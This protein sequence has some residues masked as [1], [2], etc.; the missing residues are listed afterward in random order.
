MSPI[1]RAHERIKAPPPLNFICFGPPTVETTLI[2]NL[3]QII[4][5]KGSIEHQ[6]YSELRIEDQPYSS[7]IKA[8]I[9]Q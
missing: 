3:G 5:D 8:M 7:S 9:W 2:Y 6:Y 1:P 4:T